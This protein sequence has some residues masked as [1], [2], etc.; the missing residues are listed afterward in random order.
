M[1]FLQKAIA[2]ICF[3]EAASLPPVVPRARARASWKSPPKVGCLKG[4][5]GPVVVSPLHCTPHKPQ[6]SLGYRCLFGASLHTQMCLESRWVVRGD[7]SSKSRTRIFRCAH[8]NAPAEQWRSLWDT[9]E[10]CLGVFA[11]L[12]LTCSPD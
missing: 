7:T 1:T 3:T 11:Q 6:H 2:T 5:K 10:S 9:M 4:R 8:M 12:E